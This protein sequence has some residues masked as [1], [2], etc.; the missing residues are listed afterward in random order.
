MRKQRGFTLVELLVVIAIIALLMGILLPVLGKVRK[1]AKAIVCQSNMKQLGTI[2]LMYANENGDSMP[3]T[4]RRWPDVL[5]LTS[6]GGS[7]KLLFCP[8]ATRFADEGGHHPFAAYRAFSFG[9]DYYSGYGSY[10]I[11]GWVCNP[12]SGVTT[13][14][15]GLSTSNNWRIVS[16]NGASKIPLLLDSMW[17]DSYPDATDIP[18]PVDGYGCNWGIP[19][20]SK[21]KQ[22]GTFC[23]NRHE[24]FVN[25][26]F[27]DSSVRKIGLKELWKLKW[28]RKFDT[29]APT[30]EWPDW[31]KKF[32]DY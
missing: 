23:M 32:K 8:T 19:A 17:A 31:M 30:P 21:N 4:S 25:S 20:A 10:G 9:A 29:N 14:P 18:P 26:V 12:P 7:N 6:Y 3:N 2:F 15:F 24:G 5:R 13:N 28:H 22:I 16:V 1:Q 11:N 27:L